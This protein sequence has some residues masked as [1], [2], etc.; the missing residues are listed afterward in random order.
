MF[1]DGIA[2][3]IDASLRLVGAAQLRIGRHHFRHRI[4]RAQLLAQHAERPIGDTGQS[5]YWSGQQYSGVYLRMDDIPFIH[6][7][8]EGKLERFVKTKKTAAKS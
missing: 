5:M 8:K 3:M 6:T 4:A 1:G 2:G 7:D